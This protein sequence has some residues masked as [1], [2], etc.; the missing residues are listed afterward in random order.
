MKKRIVIVG[1]G[2]VG[3][4]TAQI[5]SRTCDG[6][7]VLLIDKKCDFLFTP[8]LVDALAGEM[9]L[10][11]ITVDLS[12]LAKQDGFDFLEAEVIRVAREKRTIRLRTAV[13]EKDLPFDILVLSQGVRTSYYDIPGAETYSYPLKN[14]GDI[15]RAQQAILDT[16]AKATAEQNKMEHERLLSMAV[17]GAGPTG[18]EAIFAVKQFIERKQADGT[19]SADLK[20]RFHLIQAAPQIL[21]G[22]P[23][24]VVRHANAELD[25]HG[26]QTMT[27]EAVIGVEPG[28]IRTV[29]G[30]AV[31]ASFILWCAGIEPS[32]VDLTPP[33]IMER[34]GYPVVDNFFRIDKN[35]FCAGDVSGFKLHGVPVS[36]TAQ[37]AMQMAPIL[38]EN[39]L[40]TLDGKKLVPFRTT[41]KGVVITLGD[42][43]VISLKHKI[44]IKAKWSVPLRNSF[45]RHRFKQMTKR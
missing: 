6:F 40:R 8:W 20:P 36:K 33:P 27:G 35:I 12:D 13:S 11:D 45:Y 43:G 41:T 23:E 3:L 29:S 21:P 38:A 30:K 26:I 4:R 25:L 39:I 44:T 14:P 37:T 34:G 24:S 5:I 10:E 32:M 16:L 18:I 1:G 22:F 2:F 42:T 17:V 31:P 28:L 7:E 19:V 9:K 15:W